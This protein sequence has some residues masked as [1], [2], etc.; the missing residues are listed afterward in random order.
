MKLLFDQNLSPRLVAKL[1][2]HYPGSAHATSV[3]NVFIGAALAAKTKSWCLSHLTG[4]TPLLLVM[5]VF[6]G[7]T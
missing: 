6:S 4:V 5:R 3:S 1:A 7:Q 2:N